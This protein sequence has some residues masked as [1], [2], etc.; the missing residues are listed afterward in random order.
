MEQLDGKVEK[1]LKGNKWYHGTTLFAW[2]ELCSLGV[3]HDYNLGTEL[4]FGYGFYLTNEQKQAESYITRYLQYT[5]ESDLA[6]PV[7]NLAMPLKNIQ[8]KKIPIVIEFDFCPLE[9]YNSNSYKFGFFNKYDDDFAEFVFQNRLNASA[10]VQQHDFDIIFGVMSD[11]TPTALMEKYQNQEISKEDVISSLKKQTSVKQLSL[12]KQ[13]ICDTITL[14]RAYYVGKE[15][16]MELN[17]N[18]YFVR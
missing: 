12:H 13:E 10:G 8:D 1:Y 3:K 11:S 17:I 6:M 5:T 4:D 7:I 16:R 2:K 9:W 15:E 18:D 14:T